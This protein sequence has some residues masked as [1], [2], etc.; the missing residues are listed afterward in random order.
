MFATEYSDKRAEALNKMSFPRL[1][2]PLNL[3]ILWVRAIGKAHLCNDVRK[4]A[5]E[6]AFFEIHFVLDGI[7]SYTCGHA[8]FTLNGGEA[9]FI[10]PHTKH[11]YH[12][13]NEALKITLAFSADDNALELLQLKDKPVTRVDYSDKIAQCLNFI[14]RHSELSDLFS[15]QLIMGRVL[16]IL[17]SFLYALNV[18]IPKNSNHSRDP[19]FF[20]AKTYIDNNTDKLLTCNDVA[21]ECCLSARQLTR[22]FSAQTGESLADYISASKIKHAKRLLVDTQHSIKSIGFLLGFKNESSFVS[23]FRRHHGTPPGVFRKG[24]SEK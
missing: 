9:L 15:S 6:H 13:S 21:K 3:N 23:F 8:V 1:E 24:M 18:K 11:H 2:L 20:M 22:I 17:Y 12:A 5:H 19:R 10:P 7:I 4:R 16:E 14:L